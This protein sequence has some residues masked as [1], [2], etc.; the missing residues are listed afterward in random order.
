MA[1]FSSKRPH[2]P[3]SCEVQNAMRE[4]YSPLLPSVVIFMSCLL[5]I[6]NVQ[7]SNWSN[8]RRTQFAPAWPMTSVSAGQA[9]HRGLDDLVGGSVVQ[10]G[11]PRDQPVHRRPEHQIHGDLRIDIDTQLTA[12]D[13]AIP[14]RPRQLPPG[15][16]Q[17]IAELHGDRRVELR[18]GDE[19][20]ENPTARAGVEVDETLQGQAE[21]LVRGAWVRIGRLGEHLG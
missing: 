21:V 16:H 8:G 14:D 5:E 10:W 9:V 4:P 13:T 1:A 6:L 3:P 2:S 7:F 11:V 20:G 18:F 12:C 19:L 15:A 17:S